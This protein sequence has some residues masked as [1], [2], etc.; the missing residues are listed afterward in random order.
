MTRPRYISTAIP[1]ILAVLGFAVGH[2]VL[3]FLSA[4]PAF[5]GVGFLGTE[6]AF[7]GLVIC[8]LSIPCAILAFPFVLVLYIWSL[9]VP[10]SPPASPVVLFLTAS[11]S[12]L[13]GVGMLLALLRWAETNA[14]QG[15][16]EQSPGE[17]LQRVNWKSQ[18]R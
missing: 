17:C 8:I 14:S 11:N 10:E 5:I 9:C 2:F 15:R 16:S 3:L 4:G 7:P 12:I 13:W 6:P 18:E 1:Y